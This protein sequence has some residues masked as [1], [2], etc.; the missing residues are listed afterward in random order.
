MMLILSR[1][2]TDHKSLHKLLESLFQCAILEKQAY[3]GPKKSTKTHEKA[4]GLVAEAVRVA[5]ENCAT[6]LR[7]K[8]I[9]AIID[10]ITQTLPAPNDDGYVEP[11]LRDY[12]R[13]LAS[14]LRHPCHVEQLCVSDT[15]EGW[16]DCVDF[17]L[18]AIAWCLDGPDS[19][20]VPRSRAS[21][22]PTSSAFIGSGRSGTASSHR[23]VPQISH[24]G[25]TLEVLLLS[26][27]A[28]VSCSNAPIH[29]KAEEI[30]RTVLRAIQIRQL[31][32]TIP[33]AGIAIL[34]YIVTKVQADNLTL[35][36]R[37]T[38][39]VLPLISLWWQP[40]SSAIQ[41]DAMPAVRDEVLKLFHTLQ[42][43]LE[44]LINSNP[45]QSTVLHV[46]TALDALWTEYSRREDKLR[47]QISDLTFSSIAA[48]F[49]SNRIF[50]L[51]PFH[52]S[53][54]RCWAIV[55][56]IASFESV[57]LKA[58][59]EQRKRLPVIDEQPRKR[60]K[61]VGKVDRLRDRLRSGDITVKLTALQ[62]LPLLLHKHEPSLEMLSA[63]LMDLV[64]HLSSRH[65]NISSWSMIACARSVAKDGESRN[66]S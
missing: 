18:R 60:R 9:K 10:H 23:S 51:R 32:T 33:R 35:I 63:D 12:L 11:L 55:D 62:V 28:L 31:N 40:Q 2:A 37:I 17:L 64:N 26:L 34:G 41:G 65:S 21:P 8:V 47:L 61:I 15:Q 45:D 59:E 66:N 56:V 46:E 1:L 16:S 42:L 39:D 3:Y 27:Q 4:L 20:S 5:I 29:E 50:G 48:S 49:F 58:S 24:K 6:G 43:Q 54:E 14:M 25:R 36:E 53:A 44:S 13:A 52:V 38:K 57:L 7:R 22:G 19:D 30:S